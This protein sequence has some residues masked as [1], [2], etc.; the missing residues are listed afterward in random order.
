MSKQ[1]ISFH[2][3][4]KWAKVIEPQKV[5]VF[6]E[7]D[8]S[9][10]EDRHFPWEDWL[11]QWYSEITVYHNTKRVWDSEQDMLNYQNQHSDKTCIFITQK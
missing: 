9:V 4:L 8:N 2:A 1:T 11:A 7:A 10:I 6:A 5:V 3:K